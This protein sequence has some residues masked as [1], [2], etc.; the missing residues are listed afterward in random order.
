[1]I[2][3]FLILAA[4]SG[5][6]LA[7]PA[8]TNSAYAQYDDRYD[9]DDDY[10][11]EYEYDDRDTQS[12][13]FAEL[14]VYGRW[15]HVS[16][17]GWVWRPYVRSGW[18]PYFHGH[19]AWTEYGWMWIGY[20][21]FAWA[22]YH[23]GN[24]TYHPRWGWVWVPGYEWAP[25]HVE[26]IVYDDYVCWAPRPPRHVHLGYPWAPSRVNV[27]VSVRTQYFT[28]PNVGYHVTRPRFK[29]DYA[30]RSARFDAPEVRYVERYKGRPVRSV[31]V[32]VSKSQVGKRELRRVEL[33]AEQVHIRERN[34]VKVQTKDRYEAT[35]PKEHPK[36]Q[37]ME[38]PSKQRAK[39]PAAQQSK[40]RE[41]QKG[42]SE[43]QKGQSE[44]QKDAKGKG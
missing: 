42:Q 16:A 33:P 20:E 40:Q 1:M 9:R 24:W 44:K 15:F 41:K 37:R 36:S 39:Q 12:G 43:K 21:P 10:E 14:D 17:Y 2:R 22:A 18:R 34:S 4:I 32:R 6:F 7:G 30:E 29:A 3:H 26:W 25:S 19:W 13:M 23:Y 27:W 28:E 5:L 8:G 11:Y 35:R 38:Q 31:D